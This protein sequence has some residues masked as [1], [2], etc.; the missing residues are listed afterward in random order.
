M[1]W[2]RSFFFTASVMF[3]CKTNV[4]SFT[5]QCCTIYFWPTGFY[6]KSQCFWQH[7]IV[8]C[9]SKHITS[10]TGSFSIIRYIEGFYSFGSLGKNPFNWWTWKEVLIRLCVCVR[11]CMCAYV[12]TRKLYNLYNNFFSICAGGELLWHILFTLH[13]HFEAVIIMEKLSAVAH[14]PIIWCMGPFV[15][16]SK[17]LQYHHNHSV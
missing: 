14:N 7:F 3:V 2:L 1:F 8:F 16:S 4:S 13:D 10:E 6:T 17:T 15:R 12:D 5:F 9:F 11:T